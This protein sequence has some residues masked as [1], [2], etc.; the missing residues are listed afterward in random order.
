[1]W[2][3]ANCRNGVSSCEVAR[4]LG[5]LQKKTAWFMLHR[6]REA[7]Q[8]KTATKLSGTVEVDESFIGGKSCNMHAKRRAEVITR[9]RRC[10]G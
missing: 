5:G 7:M 4:D 3:V 9:H 1:M 6:I 10:A 2:L 8:D